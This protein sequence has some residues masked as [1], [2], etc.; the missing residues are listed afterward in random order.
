MACNDLPDDLK[1]LW[2]EAGADRPMFSPEQLRNATQ[3]LERKR[4]KGY[5]VLGVTFSACVASLAVAFFF[6]PNT[7]ARIGSVLG[8]ISCG[9]WVLYLAMER[10]R[11]ATDPAE[12]DGLRHYRAE[13]ERMRD[14]HRGIASWRLPILIP[15]FLL[16][17][18]GA[19][20]LFGKAMPWVWMFVWIDLTVFLGLLAIWGPIKHRRAAQKCQERIDALDDA[21][22]GGQH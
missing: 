15:P 13:L 19:A 20:Q 18:L 3:K 17:D 5:I 1:T 7:L 4:Q 8:V 2:K 14:W 6:F 16:F 12:T 22:R 11:T 21:L 9:Y 10:A